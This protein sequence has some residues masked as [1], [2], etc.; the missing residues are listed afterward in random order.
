MNKKNLLEIGN[1]IAT[2]KMMKRA[3]KDC[4]KT[5]IL[6]YLYWNSKRTEYQYI[7]QVRVK[8][9]DNIMAVF[10]FYTT[11]MRKGKRNPDYIVF[12]DNQQRKFVSYD[13]AEAKWRNSTLE[14]LL[15]Y[16]SSVLGNT[17]ISKRE[18]NL[19]RKFLQSKEGDCRAIK[20]F[21][22]AVRR[23]EL[24]RKRKLETEPW[25]RA[26]E[27]IPPLPKDWTTWLHKTVIS[28]HFIFYRYQ[29]NIKEGYC[30]W[31]ERSVPIT[32]PRYNAYAKCPHC[33]H[34]IQ[35]KSIGKAGIILTDKKIAY[36]LQKYGTDQMVIRE[37]QVNSIYRKG[38]YTSPKILYHEERRVIF[39]R[40]LTSEAYYYGLYKNEYHRWIK[41]AAW[42]N[43]SSYYHVNGRIY[44]R[45]LAAL[46]RDFLK[47]T[48]IYEY[49]KM[50]PL[51]DPEVYL[52]YKSRYPYIEKIVKAGL[53]NL[54]TE[55]FKKGKS[56][57]TTESDKLTKILGLDRQLLKQLKTNNGGICYLKWLQFMKKN[58]RYI[59]KDVISYFSDQGL[60]PEYFSFIKEQ[61]SPEQIRN[62]LIRQ[63]KETGES[64]QDIL[65]TWKDYLSMAEKAE[66]DL[67]D[68]IVYRPRNLQK[69]HDEVVLILEQKEIDNRLIE[70]K[71]KFPNVDKICSEIKNKYEY[72]SD[73]T[74][75]ILV[76][77]G[78]KDIMEEGLKLHH[79]VGVEECYC[80]RI[81][82][83]ESFILFLRKKEQIEQPFYTLEIEPDGTIRQ[84][85]K[86]YSRQGK[87]INEILPFL[88]KWQKIVSK[89]INEMDKQSSKVSRTLWQNEITRLYQNH[90]TI[91]GGEYA[92]M[93]LAEIL[94]KD[95]MKNKEAA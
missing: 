1:F 21:Q 77:T 80:D 76:P 60:S 39:N 4:P 40:D 53:S 67:N 61:M 55:L 56:I 30:S 5:K 18:R 7:K 95:L 43:I 91:R 81:S 6:R 74:Y 31:C 47:T 71:E 75:A 52:L 57:E 58:G 15:P 48:G 11:K 8:I 66:M 9:V 78:M 10:F 92:G 70:W 34:R 64:V 22:W 2:K 89:R 13:V 3:Q 90:I 36:I 14:K 93:S 87:E 46:N 69:R 12:I 41:S 84:K 86:E 54:A 33:G 23:D 63:E 24:V 26:M 59:A 38:Q 94:E 28:E 27:K 32:D 25:D 29:R 82:K 37:F 35:Y 50:M 83:H 19:I 72:L 68:S 73:K 51:F 44:R 20:E 85:R 49:E 45:S 17:Y 42:S 16:D 65:R 88:K 79:C 62:Y